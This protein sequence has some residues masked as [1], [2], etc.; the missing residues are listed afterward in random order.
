MEMSFSLHGFNG[1]LLGCQNDLIF[2]LVV[3]NENCFFLYVDT[4]HPPF[5]KPSVSSHNYAVCLS[6]CS[7]KKGISVYAVFCVEQVYRID[8]VMRIC[9]QNGDKH[10]YDK[11]LREE[12]VCSFNFFLK[13]CLSHRINV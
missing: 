1:Q 7:I 8:I 2:T 4:P 6:S 5:G 13:L 12:G 11:Y 10:Q 9:T 3:N